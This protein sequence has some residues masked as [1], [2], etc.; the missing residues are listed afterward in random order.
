[1]IQ[2]SQQWEFYNGY[3]D[4]DSKDTF[5][6]NFKLYWVMLENNIAEINPLEES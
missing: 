3:L 4:N 6:D 2:D 1:M 5:I